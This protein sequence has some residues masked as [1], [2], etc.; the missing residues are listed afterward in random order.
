MM[1]AGYL[2]LVANLLAINHCLCYSHINKYGNLD[3]LLMFVHTHINVI[4]REEKCNVP[5]NI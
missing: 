3:I 1:V 5:N 4:L 2:F